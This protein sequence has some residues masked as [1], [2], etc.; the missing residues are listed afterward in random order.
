M[1]VLNPADKARK[2]ARKKELKKNKK[3]RQQVRSAAIEKKDPEQLIADLEKLDKLEFDI[4]N[5]RST[6]DT[7]YK[8]K[9][10][11]LKDSWTKVLAYYQ[12]EDPERYV[13]LKKIDTEYEQ[14]YRKI[15][16]EF[17]AVKA[18]REVKIEDVFLPPAVSDLTTESEYVTPFMSG[19]KPPGCPPGLP[20]NLA[21]IAASAQ[22]IMQP[23]PAIPKKLA[24]KPIVEQPPKPATQVKGSAIIESK[25]VLIK[26]K[27]TKLIPSSL[28][29]KCVN[30]N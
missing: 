3:Q 2:E 29:S 11:K 27:T 22:H 9:R 30:K 4:A 18:A 28:R 5:S 12:K 20:P 24:P 13:K 25:P 1:K 16:R 23:K 17:E 19:I 26:T 8:D 7:L 21:D 6:S 14:K 10:K 15:S